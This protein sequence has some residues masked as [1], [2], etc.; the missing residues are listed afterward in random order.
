MKITDGAKVFIKNEKLGKY[1]FV[2]RDNNPNIPNPNCWSLL[3]GGIEENELPI[4]ALKREIIEET[5]IELYNISE[6]DTIDVELVVNNKSH[7]VKGYIYLAY[8]KVEIKDI[9]IHE[10]QKVEYFTIKEIKKQKNL[11]SW[12]LSSLDY[13]ETILEN[14]N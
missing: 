10:W 5:N 8:T 9:K 1:L 3:G 4:D 2:L 11:S 14:K 7:I 6:I 12:A 13:Y